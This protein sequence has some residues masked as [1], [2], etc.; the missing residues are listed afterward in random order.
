MIYPTLI[1]KNLS[2]K[3]KK[4]IQAYLFVFI[5]LILMLVLMIAFLLSSGV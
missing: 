5:N 2:K 3:Q 1:F 4:L